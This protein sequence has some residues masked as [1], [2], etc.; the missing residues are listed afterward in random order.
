LAE[1]DRITRSFVTRLTLLAPDIVRPFLR[2]QPKAMQLAE[3]TR[4][5]PSA[6]QEQRKASLSD[7]AK[8]VEVRRFSPKKETS[9]TAG[10]RRFRPLR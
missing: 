3:L 5:M 7:A 1:S 4:V 6:W 10:S 8:S 2:R 9:K